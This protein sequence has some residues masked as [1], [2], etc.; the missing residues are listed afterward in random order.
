MGYT[1]IA[2]QIYPASQNQWLEGKHL[3]RTSDGTP[4]VVMSPSGTTNLLIYKG[5]NATPTSFA[6]QDDAH[7][8]GGANWSYL[9]SCAIDG[10]DVIHIIQQSG[11]AVYTMMY[12]TFNTYTDLYETVDEV[13]VTPIYLDQ[14]A[15]IAVDYANKPHIAYIESTD[16]SYEHMTLAYTN[17]ISGSWKTP[18][19]VLDVGE[20]YWYYMRTDIVIDA[21]HIP[22]IGCH[23]I[24][25]AD[26]AKV[27]VGLGNA[28]NAASFTMTELSSTLSPYVFNGE[29]SLGVDSE[30]D[31]YA[32]YGIFPSPAPD[33]D[34]YFQVG[35]RK[36]VSG[37]S[38]ATWSAYSIGIDR[39]DISGTE[40]VWMMWGLIDGTD[41]HV[42]ADTYTDGLIHVVNKSGVWGA[43]KAIPQPSDFSGRMAVGKYATW[44]DNDST[45]NNR[46]FVGGRAEFD[47]MIQ[48]RVAYSYYRDY[49]YS[50]SEKV[51]NRVMI[52]EM[53]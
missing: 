35:F 32:I 2:T 47:F 21:N 8:P 10:N 48:G 20:C 30:D 14:R 23:Y 29:L 26:Y 19:Q 39:N 4:Y 43:F 16:S 40:G 9:L 1:V 36:H 41:V 7:A 25:S 6:L 28:N 50:Y 3:V 11:T 27:Q 12:H 31:H 52:L 34:D 24:N 53:G 5:N 13:A 49:W 38:W 22:F 17:R 51:N 18:V 37:A 33:Y 45:G 42:F 15:T 46:A 44:T